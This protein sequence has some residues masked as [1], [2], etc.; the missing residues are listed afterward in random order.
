MR[1]F[2]LEDIII[3][4]QLIKK[5]SVLNLI[6][7]AANHDPRVFDAAM[8]F[9]TTIA[10]PS[11]LSFGRGI[12]HCLGAPLARLEAGIAVAGFFEAFPAATLLN[13]KRNK[14]MNF[15][16]CKVLNVALN[17]SI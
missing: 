17:S 10:Q 13:H 2:A 12:H 4:E 6:L 3:K 11:H 5:G 16:G 8:N 1:R 7:G 14:T 9:D 15:R